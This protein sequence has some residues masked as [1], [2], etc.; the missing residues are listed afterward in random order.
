MS[1]QEFEKNKVIE[2]EENLQPKMVTVEIA[3]KPYQVPAGI[4]LMKALWYTGHEVIRGA[5][6][7]GG[8]CGAC[9]TYYRTKD[10]P[11][12]KTCL[13]CSFAVEDGMSFS[14]APPFPARKAIYRMEELKDPKQDLFALYPEAPLCR[15]CNACTE[16]CP[17]SI[18]V[19]EGVWRAV[20]GDFKAVSEMFMNCVMCGLCAPVC[21]ADIAPN[22]VALYASRA[23]G[24]YF[25][26]KPS[27]LAERIQAIANGRYDEEWNRILSMTDEELEQ[28]SASAA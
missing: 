11:R 3:G 1:T 10:D 19:R 12:V 13:A 22:F 4:T 7:L 24:V 2:Q 17:Q 8:F 28:A 21:I 23:Q 16:A 9:G 14:F 5:G 26:D 6:C 27:G 25:T 18:D 20:F 15:N